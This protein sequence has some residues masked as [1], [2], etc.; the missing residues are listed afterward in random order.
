[1]G[2]FRLNHIMPSWLKFIAMKGGFKIAAEHEDSCPIVVFNFSHIFWMRSYA[3]TWAT[4]SDSEGKRSSIKMRF[5]ELFFRGLPIV[6]KKTKKKVNFLTNWFEN[7]VP[8]A[9]GCFLSRSFKIL[10]SWG[11]LRN[12]KKEST[13]CSIVLFSTKK[14]TDTKNF[15]SKDCSMF[16]K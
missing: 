6:L 3:Q 1:M 8:Y 12:S 16:A 5:C 4:F 14:G 7:F 2:I 13:A 9:P 10:L 15:S 11:S